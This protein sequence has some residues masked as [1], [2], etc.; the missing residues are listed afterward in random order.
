MAQLSHL[1]PYVWLSASPCHPEGNTAGRGDQTQASGS[2]VGRYGASSP[3]TATATSTSTTPGAT[4]ITGSPTDRIN[5]PVSC[6]S[7]AS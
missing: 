1:G 4:S 7:A 5:D 6:D 3:G 2:P